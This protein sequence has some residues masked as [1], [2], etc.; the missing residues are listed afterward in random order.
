MQ[1][2]YCV[3]NVVKHLIATGRVCYTGE[4]TI[5]ERNGIAVQVTRPV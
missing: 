1:T 5:E 2:P 4:S 3:A